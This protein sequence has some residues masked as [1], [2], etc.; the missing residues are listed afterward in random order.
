MKVLFLNIKLLTHMDLRGFRDERLFFTVAL[1]LR[2]NLRSN[3]GRL[4]Y[5]WI[6]FLTWKPHRQFFVCH[7]PILPTFASALWCETSSS[8]RFV[9]PTLRRR[10]HWEN[11]LLRTTLKTYLKPLIISHFVTEKAENPCNER[12]WKLKTYLKQWIFLHFETEK[13]QI[14]I[15]FYRKVLSH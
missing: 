13:S 8:R 2:T 9:G 4:R 10:R 12:R 3:S 11:H 15:S 1:W 7:L 5:N 6:F 14:K